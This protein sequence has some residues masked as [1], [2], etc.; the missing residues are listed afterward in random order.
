[1][2]EK[3]RFGLVYGKPV[4]EYAVT[5]ANGMSVNILTYGAIIRNIIV[6]DKNGKMSDVVCGYDDIKS[7]VE[8]DGYQGAVVGRCANR[9]ANGKFT[10]GGVEYTLAKNDNGINS[11][12]GGDVGLNQ[13][14]YSATSDAKNNCVVLSTVMEDMEEGYPGRVFL[15]VKYT[16]TDANEL[17]IDYRAKTD[18]D[19]VINITNHAYFNLGGFASGTVLGHKLWMD[20]DTFLPTNDALIPTGELRPVDGTPFDFREEK[21]LGRDFYEDY[22]PL[23]QAGGYDHCMNFVGGESTELLHRATLRHPENGRV[24]KVYTNQPAVQLYTANFMKNGNYPFKGGFPQHAQNAV[25]LETQHMPDSINHENFTDVV[26]RTG[27]EYNY[28]TVYAF[29]VE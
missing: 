27:E 21:E 17:K 5:N 3:K 1:M 25:C 16:L 8:G 14:L 9:I 26:L 19:T 20:A 13:K 12:H 29:G 11:L 2:I 24:M 22:A 7:Y 15:E 10:L 4:Y 18:K 23:V 28:T 6:P